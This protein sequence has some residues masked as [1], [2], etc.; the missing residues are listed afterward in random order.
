MRGGFLLVF[1]STA[2]AFERQ[3]AVLVTSVAAISDGTQPVLFRNQLG[4]SERSLYEMKAFITGI[5]VVV[6]L[7]FVA[8]AE[9]E[10]QDKSTWEKTK[11]A[12]KDAGQTVAKTSKD[13]AGAIVETVTP[14]KD[15]RR[16]N[17]DLTGDG[18]DMPKSMRAGKTAFVVKNRAHEKQNFEIRGDGID[19][20]FVFNISPDETKT[21]QTTLKRGRYQAYAIRKDGKEHRYQ[22]HLTVR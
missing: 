21:L 22:I 14:D 12:T 18:I 16:V 19:R 10:Q 6:L 5:A 1:L 15:A 20:E 2:G 11:E 3:Q 8:R 7:P 17:V 4:I 9:N 13:V